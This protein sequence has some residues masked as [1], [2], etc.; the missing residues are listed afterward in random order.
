[1]SESVDQLIDRRR[2][3][4]SVTL[5]RVLGL[6]LLGVVMIM[7]LSLAGAFSGTGTSS[8]HI[9]RIA[10]NGVIT[11]DRDMIKLLETAAEDPAVK[12]VIVSI[13]SPGG[14]TVGGEALFEA[15]RELAKK[16]PT[17]TSVGTLAASAG[18]MIATA[19]DHIVARRT[20]IV[21]SIGVIMQYP[22]ATELLDR[23]GVKVKE[24]KSAPLKAEPSPFN[25]TPPAAEAMLQNMIDDSY[26]WFAELVEGRRGLSKVELARV[27]DGSVFTGGQA[28]TLKLVD[29]IGG[30]DIAQKWLVQVKKLDKSLEVVDWKPRNRGSI[31]FPA[32]QSAILNV[33]FGKEVAGRIADILGISRFSRNPKLL[34]LWTG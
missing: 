3:R 7:A 22:E 9:A 16:K 17:V 23:L 14:T 28:K 2:L 13:D 31:F 12:G 11:E 5:W 21:G 32:N 1:M 6:A 18:Y 25:P 26:T 29:A 19:T 20:S 8:A 34:S 4:R 15:V 30:E 24:V 10:I 33:V 27:S